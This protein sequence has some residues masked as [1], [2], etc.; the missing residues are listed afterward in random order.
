ML[1]SYLACG[2]DQGYGFRTVS[3][4]FHGLFFTDVGVESSR[5]ASIRP[6]G[7]ILCLLILS[8]PP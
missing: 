4:D 8:E 3:H 7:K 1:F 2:R 6:G 5:Q